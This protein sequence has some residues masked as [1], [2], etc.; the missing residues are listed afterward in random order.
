MKAFTITKKTKIEIDNNICFVCWPS[1]N[2][3]I[4]TWT[5]DDEKYTP[6][7][8]DW[9][10]VLKR[11]LDEKWSLFHQMSD[12]SEA[13][14]DYACFGGISPSLLRGI[15]VDSIDFE[16][17]AHIASIINEIIIDNRE[18]EEVKQYL[19]EREKDKVAREGLKN[20]FKHKNI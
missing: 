16:R 15:W 12:V 7:L 2:D 17:E 6:S 3:F 1:K 19:E 10:N 14:Y 18:S 5:K 13:L 4:I 11:C 9:V 8:K 20:F